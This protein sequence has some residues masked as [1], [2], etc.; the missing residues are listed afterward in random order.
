M[1]KRLISK[2]CWTPAFAGSLFIPLSKSLG[3]FFLLIHCYVLLCQLLKVIL[4][5]N[6]CGRLKVMTGISDVANSIGGGGCHT[7]TLCKEGKGFSIEMCIYV[8]L[9][10]MH[11]RTHTHTLI[12]AHVNM[13][14]ETHTNV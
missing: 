11:V 1:I 4:I 2:H 6:G 8:H 10:S 13:C 3:D 7:L 14:I 5:V 9:Q 12:C